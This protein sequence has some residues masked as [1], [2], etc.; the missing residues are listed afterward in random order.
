MSSGRRKRVLDLVVVAILALLL[1]L[2]AY[3]QYDW[4]GKVSEREGEQMRSTLR[5]T[6]SQFRQQFDH[7]ITRIFVQFAPQ[8]DLIG[9]SAAEYAKMYGH[10]N[11]T[12]SHPRLIRDIFWE[13]DMAPNGSERLRKLNVSSAAWEP[14]DWITEFGPQR[15]IDEPVDGTI[16]AIV[17]PMLK[18]GS[19]EAFLPMPMGERVGRLIVHLDLEYIKNEFVPALVRS[20]FAD[21]IAEYKVQISVDDDDSRI[22]YSSAPAV[23]TNNDADAQESLLEVR[24]DEYKS[25]MPMVV[26]VGRPDRIEVRAGKVLSFGVTG[27]LSA[28]PGEP[29]QMSIAKS[30]HM[31][32]GA[33]NLKA[34]HNSGSLNVAV[35]QLRR[36][37][38]GMSLSILALLASSVAIVLRS[39]ARARHL[40]QQQMEFVSAVSHELRTP[41]AVICSAGEN[42]ADGVV[43]DAD[44]LISYGK[45]VRNEGRRLTEMVEQVLSF[46]EI[47]SGPKYAFLPI[48]LP[49]VVERALNAFETPIRSGG[50]TVDQ[51]IGND[52][53]T[54]RGDAVALTRAL[55]NLISNAIKY[56]GSSRWIGISVFQEDRW[57]KVAVQDHGAG[58]ASSDLPHIFE[59]FFRGRLAIESQIKGSGLGLSLIKEIVDAHRGRIH[60]TSNLSG[61]TTV[62]IA[63]PIPGFA[64]TR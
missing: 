59:P 22:I 15:A 39:A 50:F 33:W 56:S 27:P 8:P 61:G 49:A 2:L 16:P 28:L 37:N 17:I 44:Q 12:A 3:L 42:L 14:A 36:R 35:A 52:I 11:A 10:W 18:R 24:L 43:R 9:Q 51:H 54:V 20:N 63:L 40:A 31:N 48:E 32:I 47:Q 29:I 5:R 21:L 30:M 55:Q 19:A 1:P 13:D 7:E 45:A 26:N 34:V 25:L 23:T 53:P 62:C 6:L 38:L 58:I 57:A 41:L 4:L 46:A 60:V 64:E